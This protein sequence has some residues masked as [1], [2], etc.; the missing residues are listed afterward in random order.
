MTGVASSTTGDAVTAA[1]VEL[2]TV[3]GCVS[4]NLQ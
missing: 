2:Q 4:A 1:T 3:G